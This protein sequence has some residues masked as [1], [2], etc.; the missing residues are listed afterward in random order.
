MKLVITGSAG[1]ISKPLTEKL[2]SAGNEVTVV[3]R[4]V[5]NIAG[6]IALGAKTAIGSV[7]DP[8]FLINTFRG[9]HAVYTMVPPKMTVS[10]WKGFIEQ[11]GTNY[12]NAIRASGVK[13]VVN[14]SSVGAHLADGCGPVS[15]IHRAENALNTLSDVN[16]R[17]LRPGFFYTNLLENI[18]MIRF[19]NVIGANFGDARTK[20]VLA[21][22]A[23]IASVAVNELTS[24]NFKGHSFLYIAS[25]E[26]TTGDIAKTFGAAIGK[27]EL[28]W[29][30][31]TDEQ[32]LSGMIQAG[33]PSEIAK[34]YVE[35][36]ASIR[37]GKM[38]EDYFKNPP[39]ALGNIKLED[40]AKEFKA[41]YNSE[42]LVTA[43]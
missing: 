9:A 19:M 43:H 23:D 3:S 39:S 27:P 36:G 32:S 40:F 28:P 14:L 20:M 22:P 30:S 16:I 4:S 42:K 6:L 15:G 2:L 8:K 7:E 5:N 31:F 26:R 34:N 41:A 33:L 21:H 37:S 13:Y 11:I 10:D 29:I 17:H 12:A 38:N 35:M 24:L 18:N 1:H 25:D